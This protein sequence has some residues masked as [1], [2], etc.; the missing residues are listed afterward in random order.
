MLQERL[1]E[2]AMIMCG[3]E[4]ARQSRSFTGKESAGV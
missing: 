1:D 4:Q 2:R 3:G